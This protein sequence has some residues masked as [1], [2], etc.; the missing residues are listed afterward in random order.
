M[1]EFVKDFNFVKK[2]IETCRT[3]NEVID[4][5]ILLDMFIDKYVVQASHTNPIFQ[6]HKNHLMEI[7]QEKFR[8]FSSCN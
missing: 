7:Y 3:I 4:A 6:S 8:S 2:R 1:T 5:K